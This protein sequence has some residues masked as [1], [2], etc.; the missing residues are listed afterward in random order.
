[1]IDSSSSGGS[2]STGVCCDLSLSSLALVLLLLLLLLLTLTSNLTMN[3]CM[4][5]SV[6]LIRISLFWKK[7]EEGGDLLC[8][9]RVVYLVCVL[10][11]WSCFLFFFF[12]LLLFVDLLFDRLLIPGRLVGRSVVGPMFSIVSYC[13]HQHHHG[14]VIPVPARYKNRTIVPV[15]TVCTAQNTKRMN[16]SNDGN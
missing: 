13:H 15:C 2:G 1:M 14:I 16:E 12:L 3:G 7:I 10:L 9:I 11:L 5:S 8:V 4:I 6:H